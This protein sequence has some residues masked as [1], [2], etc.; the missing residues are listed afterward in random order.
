MAVFDISRGRGEG[1]SQAGMKAYGWKLPLFDD[2][3]NL[4]VSNH[5]LFDKSAKKS[6]RNIRNESD[7]VNL[8]ME[9][10]RFFH[11]RVCN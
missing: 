7:H 5:F 4:T 10:L 8:L 1:I 3:V 11:D 6:K 2:S 9:Y